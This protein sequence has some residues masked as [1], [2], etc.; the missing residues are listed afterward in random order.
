MPVFQPLGQ[1]SM[2]QL[3]GPQ[4]GVSM[5]QLYTAQS[6]QAQQIALTQQ[7][8][9]LNYPTAYNISQMQYAPY[10][11]TF[12]LPCKKISPSFIFLALL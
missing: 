2:H 4:T 8:A 7:I 12:S 11:A 1:N 6:Q 10:P 5:H 3:P 9:A